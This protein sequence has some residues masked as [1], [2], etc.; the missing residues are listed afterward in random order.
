VIGSSIA[1]RYA[2]AFFRIAGEEARHE[3]CQGE[4]DRISALLKDNRNLDDFLAN[5]LFDQ[6]DKQAVMETLLKKAGVSAL[7]A[8]FIK[9]L[10]DKRRIGI[11]SA[12]EASYRDLVDEALQKTR[13]T[14]RTAFPLTGELADSLRK[15]LAELTGREVEMTVLEDPSLLGGISVRIGN[16]LY[17]G[18]IRTQLD[19]IRNRLGEEI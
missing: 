3:A 15:G 10:V 5:P 8:N 6:T 14:V 9:L 19:N 12:I 11:L 16:T 2:R 13:V 17:D 18:S 7:T 4:L 1:R